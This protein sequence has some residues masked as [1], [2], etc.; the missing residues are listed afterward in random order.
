MT[1]LIMSPMNRVAM[2]RLNNQIICG[3]AIGEMK[4]LPASS[5][6]LI[7]TSP[8]Y[9]N[10]IDYKVDGQFGQCP[11]DEY[12][13]QMLATFAEAQRILK[14][15]GKLAIVTP[16][17]PV[18][19]EVDSTIHTRKLFNISSDIEHKIL[20][21]KETSELHRFSLY[22]WQKQTSKKMFGSYPYP[23]N[24]YED[25]TIEFINIF[26]KE[27]KPAKIDKAIK[28]KSKMAQNEWLNLSMQVWPIMPSDIQRT[29]GH[30]APFPVEIPRRLMRMYTFQAVPELD[31]EGDL[32]LDMF[33]GSGS[34]CVAAAELKRRYIGIELNYDYCQIAQQRLALVRPDALPPDIMVEKIRMPKNSNTADKN[35]KENDGSL[36]MQASA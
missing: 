12:L 6:S 35:G 21:A 10:L 25:N 32:V 7:V 33:A 14:P 20:K 2:E 19:K 36:F 18:S 4:K 13:D 30:P 8:P 11:Y 34:T 15:N 26:V 9:W 31:F 24:I 1:C 16:I 23:P 3:D 22:I 5:V 17:V 29:K 27:G 28:E